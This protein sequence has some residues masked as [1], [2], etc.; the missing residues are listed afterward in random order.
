MHK[1]VYCAAKRGFWV[2]IATNGRLLRPGLA[3]RLG[4]AGV[5]AFNFAM[6]AWDSK[7]GPSQSAGPCS[8]EPGIYPPQT[9]CEWLR[10][11]FLISIF[12]GTA[13]L[14]T[15]TTNPTYIRPED[16]RAVD[17]LVD[18]LIEKNRA[19]YHM[20]NS[21]Q[22]LQEIKALVRMS[23]GV[24]LGEHGWNGDGTNGSGSHAEWLSGVPGIVR[25]LDGETAILRMELPRRPK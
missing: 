25:R 8:K 3:D 24:D 21:V 18:R 14:S 9:V 7:P 6:D 20:V 1:V 17:A 2:Y 23:S 19:G 16:W 11:L 12:V 13:C 10:R 4:D 15:C 22:R 5:S